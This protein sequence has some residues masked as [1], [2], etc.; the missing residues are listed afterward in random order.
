MSRTEAKEK[1]NMEN[2]KKTM[3]NV[4]STTVNENTLDEAPFAYKPIEEIIEN[5]KDMIE[6]V[7]IIKPIY[8]FKA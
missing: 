1:L 6:I 5:T 2:F 7:D 8:N 4:Y 3:Q